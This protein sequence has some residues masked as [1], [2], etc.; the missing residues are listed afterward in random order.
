MFKKCQGVPLNIFFGYNLFENIMCCDDRN[1]TYPWNIST[2][3]KYWS[4][5]ERN[6]QYGTASQFLKDGR[7]GRLLS[8]WFSNLC[9]LLPFFHMSLSNL[10]CDELDKPSRQT[11]THNFAPRRG[12][13]GFKELLH[14]RGVC[15]KG[16]SQIAGALNST[17]HKKT[18]Y[19]SIRA[20]W[21]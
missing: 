1:S 16:S 15:T 13:I 17:V 19:K 18:T 3:S 5:A 9:I 4:L 11:G 21:S 7:S 8:I 10:V 14:L 20:W 6:K 12:G 2:L